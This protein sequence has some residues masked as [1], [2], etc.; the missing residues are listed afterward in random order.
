M[1]AAAHDGRLLAVDVASGRVT[2]LAASQDGPVEGLAWSLDS[3]WLAWSQP[4][5]R[6]LARI[7]MARIV[8]ADVIDVT[9]GRFAD[10]S[11]A[12]ARK[13]AHVSPMMPPPMIATSGCFDMLGL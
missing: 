10:T 3:A 6:P 7:R 1:A 8:G 13:Y 11:P 12:F 2:E 9:D 4:E 5:L